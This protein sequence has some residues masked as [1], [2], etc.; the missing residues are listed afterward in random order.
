MSGDSA[1]PSGTGSPVQN[2]SGCLAS[3][4]R[5]AGEFI[6]RK[7]GSAPSAARPAG[8]GAPG[9][10]RADGNHPT[11]VGR[12]P[13]AA[14]VEREL[15]MAAQDVEA[16]LRRVHVRP[17]PAT[18][19]ERHQG[20]A[21]VNRT[22]VAPHQGGSP[23]PLHA[24]VKTGRRRQP[25]RLRLLHVIHAPSHP[26]P[27]RGL[28]QVWLYSCEDNGLQGALSGSVLL[29]KTPR[30]GRA[31]RYTR[32]M[33]SARVDDRTESPGDEIG[34]R[35]RAER[36]RQGLSLRKLAGRLE[37][38]PSALSQIETGRSRPSVSTLYG[39]VSELGISFDELFARGS[40]HTTSRTPT[41]HPRTVLGEEQI[42]Q[43]A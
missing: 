38:S 30:A 12:Q 36:E 23:E 19:V 22:H 5:G 7:S 21:G 29:N 20:E 10:G 17:H 41:R 42:V 26:K 31:S 27:A 35:L 3:R 2:V 39:I 13:V 8:G 9:V 14:T 43:R 28:R 11:F 1:A 18:R 16:L 34:S 37:I 40:Q 33:E 32:P 24:P 25:G 4:R 6:S 15:R